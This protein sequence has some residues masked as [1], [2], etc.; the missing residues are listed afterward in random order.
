MIGKN[1]RF[2]DEYESRSVVEIYHEGNFRRCPD[3]EINKVRYDPQAIDSHL[4]KILAYVDVD[5]IRKKHFKVAFDCCNGAGSLMTPKLLQALGCQLIPINTEP[6]G[7]FPRDPEPSPQNLTQL[8]STTKLSGADIGF[9]QDADAD[10]HDVDDLAHRG[11]ELE[12]FQF[13][14]LSSEVDRRRPA[15]LTDQVADTQH[16][17]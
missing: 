7:I 9:A 10:H 6:N 11:R 1:G 8:C 5:L 15:N 2:L 3:E 13:G 17:P 14:F 16:T 4:Q 12:H